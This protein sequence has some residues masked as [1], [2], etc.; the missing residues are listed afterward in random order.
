MSERRVR[1][2]A[3]SIAAVSLALI[4]A[5]FLFFVATTLHSG[6][7]VIDANGTGGFVIGFTFPIVGA[8]VA[9][10]RPQNPIGW[11][12]LAI[13]LTQGLNVFAWLYA[14]YGLITVPGSL[15]MA[16]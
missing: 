6:Q 9:S 8:I 15:P 13:G 16:D 10:R 3:Y 2:L 4:S 1:W 14:E 11:I 7:F 12:Y 5:G